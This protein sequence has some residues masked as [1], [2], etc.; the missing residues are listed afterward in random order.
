[1]QLSLDEIAQVLKAIESLDCAEVDLTLGD[2]HLVVRRRGYGPST[3]SFTTGAAVAPPSVSAAA[4]PAP[5]A[6]V[7]ASPPAPAPLRPPPASSPATVVGTAM[8][9]WL[10]RE[11]AG[12]LAL[13]RAPM[14]GTFYQAKE[15]GAPPFV[16]VGATVTADAT[17]CLVEVMKLFHSVPAGVAGTVEQIFVSDAQ[18]VEY[19]QPLIAIRKQP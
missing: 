2:L 7:A 9:E 13:V 5:A 19:G 16:E 3:T 11:A 15:P 12:E 8:G 14:V 17:V 18:V 10:A 4:A 1:V 6:P